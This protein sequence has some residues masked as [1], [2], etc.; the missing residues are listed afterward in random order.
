MHEGH[1]LD[2]QHPQALDKKHPQA[3]VCV[4]LGCI[5]AFSGMFRF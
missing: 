4:R 1:G 3:R 2:K 5:Q